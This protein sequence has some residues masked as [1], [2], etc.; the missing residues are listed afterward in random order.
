LYRARVLARWAAAL[1]A[2]GTFATIAIPLLPQ[3]FE[4]PL[5]FPTGVALAGLGYSL[6]RTAGTGRTETTALSAGGHAP[7]PATA[8]A[9]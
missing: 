5:A 1:L 3:S 4:R 7:H 2:V 9:K 6:W 8:G